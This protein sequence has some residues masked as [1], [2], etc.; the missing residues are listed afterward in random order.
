MNH[1][2]ILK[3]AGTDL[4]HMTVHEENSLAPHKATVL[5]EIKAGV[6]PNAIFQQAYLDSDSKHID[7]IIIS[8]PGINDVWRSGFSLIEEAL[9]QPNRDAREFSN[10]GDW[11]GKPASLMLPDGNAV[12][13]TDAYKYLAMEGLF[14]APVFFNWLDANTVLQQPGA[15]M[16]HL[17]ARDAYY[18]QACR[19]LNGK[20]VFF[21]YVKAGDDNPVG[22]FAVTV[23]GLPYPS[24]EAVALAY[25]IPVEWV[26]DRL[27]STDEQWRNWT[28]ETDLVPAG[29]ITAVN[30]AA[31]VT[32]N[33]S[34]QYTGGGNPN[35]KQVSIRGKIY[36]SIVDAVRANADWDLTPSMIHRRLRQGDD[37]E[38]FYCD[39]EGNKIV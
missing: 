8:H 24:V 19:V 32:P 31:D 4:K 33:Q 23:D 7:E 22:N 12:V 36:P 30:Q 14:S 15:V 17:T 28:Y 21:G 29:A 11:I 25:N 9:G 6:F 27:D 39:A 35:A 3:I 38:I 37:A 26:Y 5:S 18:D 13:V 20:R 1:L 2:L 10:L 34:E 16:S